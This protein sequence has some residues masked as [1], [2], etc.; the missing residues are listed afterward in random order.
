LGVL[1]AC[2][3]RCLPSAPVGITSTEYAASEASALTSKAMVVWKVLAAMVPTSEAQT[4]IAETVVAN[5]VCQASVPSVWVAEPV[6]NN[7][8]QCSS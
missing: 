5:F 8:S 6:G 1:C 7:S 4:V 3:M 2:G